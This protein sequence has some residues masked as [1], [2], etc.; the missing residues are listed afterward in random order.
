MSIGYASSYET[1]RMGREGFV[2][3]Q[4]V[5]ALN[6]W[7]VPVLLDRFEYPEVARAYERVAMSLAK[8]TGSPANLVLTPDLE[9]FAAAGVLDAPA[10]QRFLIGAVNRWDGQREK[11]V[12][13]ARAAIEAARPAAEKATPMDDAA[14]EAV[15]DGIAATY[16]AQHGGFG[17]AP[18]FLRPMTLSFLFR[19]AQRAK[20]D[21]IRQVGV[22]TIRKMAV[23]AIHDQLGSG[24]HHATHDAAWKQPQFEKLLEDQALMAMASLEAWQ[25][26]QDPELAG[27]TRAILDF[28]LRDMHA[29][30]GGFDTSMDAYSLVPNKGPEHYNGAFYYWARPELQH[31]FRDK[32][33]RLYALYGIDEIEK[34]IPV[35]AMPSVVKEPDIPAIVRK[36]YEIRQQR[37][38]PA[39]DFNELAGLQGLMISALARAGAAFD[40]KRYTSA[41]VTA[42]NLVTTKLWDAKKKKLWR[43]DAATKPRVEAL[44]DDY[45][46]L[47]EGLLD[48]FETTY[49][50]K[51]LELALT[52]QQRQDELFWNTAAGR[53]TTG[54]SVPAP[55]RALV[56]DRDE[57]TPSA[58]AAS[59]QNLLRLAA[60]TGTAAYSERAAMIF[61]AYA[62]ALRARG[63]ELAQLTNAYVLSLTPPK[64]VVV[65]ADP[66][67][68]ESYDLL[69]PLYERYTPLRGI[70]FVPLKG[71]A[72]ERMERLVPAIKAMKN[73]TGKP[74][75]WVC[76]SGTCQTTSDPSTLLKL[77]GG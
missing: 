25:L 18:K 50:A 5:K 4:N 23:S 60:F 67:K 10:L 9:P 52:L 72:R 28:V 65:V 59:A 17:T 51:W 6:E 37:P 34:T 12:A 15:V 24:F 16:D 46:L 39:R 69:R 61:A 21:P 3:P 77:V 71:A 1:F 14:V 2:E 64:Q 33:P 68:K 32:A 35:L 49:D 54:A 19:Y 57:G 70:L 76:S 55:L 53:Y 29:P 58:N 41:A 36:M 63:S 44:P 66:R 20:Y 73:E 40:E 62:G 30:S 38:A 27:L 8:V 11:T 13:E 43:S 7:F 56:V 22:D 45:A 31:T 74:V 42:A 48:L 26:T 47:V 75:A